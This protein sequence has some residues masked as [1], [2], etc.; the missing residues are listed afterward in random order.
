MLGKLIKYE[1]KSVLRIFLPLYIPIILLSVTLFIDNAF[2]SSISTL[3]YMVLFVALSV[4]TFIVI[5]QRFN[6]QLLG[7]EG[8]LMFTLPV[9][10]KQII[11]SKLIVAVLFEILSSL[12][13]VL[14]FCIG[15]IFI[16]RYFS[17]DFNEILQMLH[18]AFN[19]I[20]GNKTL[21]GYVALS[22]IV[23]IF[24]SVL[25]IYFALSLGQLPIFK[26]RRILGAIVSGF[27]VYLIVLIL[28]T[29]LNSIEI[30][31]IQQQLAGLPIVD[32][33]QIKQVYDSI[34]VE[35]FDWLKLLFKFCVAVVYFLGTSYILD[36]KLNLE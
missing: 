19:F 28:N 24:S 33:S 8:Y 12:V 11:L 5:V 13:V 32:D 30:A 35:L 20:T 16:S 18:S 22:S 6:K 9:S 7:D 26:G 27:V 21:S 31:N 25:F 1:I 29:I 3:L 4:T 2:V 34:S 23:S 10:S 15:M 36:H 14:S 17:T